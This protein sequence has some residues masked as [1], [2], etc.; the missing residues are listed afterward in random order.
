MVG[1]TGIIPLAP[2]I[3]VTAQ[4]T[5]AQAQPPI[6]TTLSPSLIAP[7]SSTATSPSA[8]KFNLTSKQ[9]PTAKQRSRSSQPESKISKSRAKAL[10]DPLSNAP[11]TAPTAPV[12]RRIAPPTSTFIRVRVASHSNQLQIATSTPAD[13]LDADDKVIAS[14]NPNHL[15]SAEIGSNGLQIGSQT[16]P[17]GALINP[18]SDGLTFVDGHWYRGVMQLVYDGASLLAINWVDLEDYLY[19]AVGAEMPPSWNT[20]ALCSQAIAAR[21]YAL[22][23]LEQPASPYFDLGNDEYHQVYRGIETET[24]STIAA[25]ETTRAQVLTQN[26]RILMAQYASTEEVSREAHGGAGMS[27]MGAQHLAEAGYHYASILQTYYPSA[28]LSL[29]S[30]TSN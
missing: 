3:G 17:N 25:V 22:S 10:T 18:G 9:Q 12:Q 15:Y 4:K 7:S 21:S 27:Q 13:I 24:D 19:G 30:T 29:L 1:V 5:T 2:L 26:G 11:T 6:P 23:F 28:Q 16:I 14:L 8:T 20:E